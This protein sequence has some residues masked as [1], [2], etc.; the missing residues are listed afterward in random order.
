MDDL[1]RQLTSALN[2]LNQAA[3]KKASAKQYAVR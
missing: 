2:T 3:S 1:E